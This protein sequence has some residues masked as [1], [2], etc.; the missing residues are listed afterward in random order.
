MKIVIDLQGAQSG[1][2][3][4]GIGR[5][6]LALAQAMV[7][8]GEGHEFVLALNG[9]FPETIEPIRAAFDGLLN[10]DQI[11][12]WSAAGPVHAFDPANN[13]HRH[14]A[15]LIRE[16]FLASLNPDVVHI[17]SLVEGFDDNAVH[18]VGLLPTPYLTAATFYDVIPLI[19]SDVYLKA[20]PVFEAI[21]REKI[22]HLAKVDVFLA[23]SDSSRQEAIQYLHVQPDQVVDIAAAADANFQPMNISTQVETALR[24]RLGLTRPFLMY[25]GA[26]DERKNH[27]RLIKA[28]SLLPSRVRK[29]FQLALVGRLP[30][31]HQAAFEAQIVNCGLAPASV[32][33]TGAV[34]DLEMQQLYNLCHLFV[35]P[36]WHEGFGLPAL[37]AMACGA[38]V[39]GSN[40]TSVPE[41]IG[42]T[43][44]LFDP[45]DEQSIA[46]K[47]EEVL[48]QESFRLDLKRH[49]LT[50]AMRFS[51]DK[52]AQL[53][54]EKL[55][56]VYAQ[57][58]KRSVSV[59]YQDFPSTLVDAI[60]ASKNP[61]ASP[62]IWMETAKAIAQN[63]PRINQPQM[64][65]DISELVVHD[66]KSGIQ[67]VVRSVLTALLA[68]APPGYTIEPVFATPEVT[69]YRYARSFHHHFLNQSTEKY[70]FDKFKESPI[71]PRR[72]DIFLG[73]DMQLGVVFAQ[74]PYLKFLQNLGV[75]TYFL[76]YDLIPIKMPWAYPKEWNQSEL[77][78]RW[79][80]ILQQQTGLICISRTVADEIQQWLNDF[81]V[82]RS[83]PL[84]IGWF[85]L[86]ADIAQSAPTQGFDT[87]TSHVKT[88][89]K[90]RQTFLSV[91]TLEPRKSQTQMLAAFELLWAQGQDIN[92]VLIGK[93][94]WNGQDWDV[95]KFCQYLKT[96]PE[97][98]RRLFWLDSISDEYLEAI[99]QY[100]DCL[101]AASHAE[102][103]GLPLIEAAM[104]G[105]PIIARD[106]P[107]FREVAGDHALYFYG[108]TAR[109]LANR[110]DDW[111]KLNA[112]DKTP[113]SKGITWLTWKQ[114]TENLLDIILKN[115]WNIFGAT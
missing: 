24:K 91:G 74:E 55:E 104:H 2:R 114:S 53:A 20:N 85:H 31:P 22:R 1:S 113:P 59:T 45:F 47:M 76:V 100:A 23:I 38:A 60:S 112:F 46:K 87:N 67:R 72:G 33:I 70:T 30:G 8:R 28:Y 54:L 7:R 16:A 56:T 42:R 101:I 107:V 69:G 111:L 90:K 15:E 25:S 13:W 9:L 61:P 3:H 39:I 93:K 35:F 21:Y 40:T 26:T 63:H 102:G 75:K 106:I 32:V 80:N 71:E 18:S 41:V 51:W 17:S 27:L 109:S 103:F 78:S 77:H 49:G 10:Q 58:K 89:L 95:E 11:R 99:Y 92:L 94:G 73:L 48:L 82:Q 43:D 62:H 12:V 37:E 97:N 110:I 79:L 57:R 36:S 65:V 64:Y 98:Q 115:N 50:Q 83:R 34:S 14:A 66:S 81:G 96:H 19:Q 108:S 84:K 6:S 68:N 86:G 4:R 105:L 52:S 29:D 44:A 88:E 5:Y